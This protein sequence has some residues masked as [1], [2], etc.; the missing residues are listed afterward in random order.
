MITKCCCIKQHVGVTTDPLGLQQVHGCWPLVLQLL[1]GDPFC[2]VWDC[3]SWAPCESTLPHAHMI[4]LMF[5]IPEFFLY[6]WDLGG[7]WCRNS[8][9]SSLLGNL[10]ISGRWN[11]VDKVYSPLSSS[12]GVFFEAI[13][14]RVLGRRSEQ[15]AA[16]ITKRFSSPAM[17]PCT[18]T[19]PWYSSSP[20]IQAPLPSQALWS[21]RKW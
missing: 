10:L 11:P 17:H 20:S 7:S 2:M 6:C 3:L 4:Q 19:S 16:L 8:G 14:P 21:L 9:K 13:I 15:S 1:C 12:Q 18:G 5:L